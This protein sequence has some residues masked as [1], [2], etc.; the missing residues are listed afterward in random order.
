MACKIISHF[1][2]DEQ[3]QIQQ[4]SDQAEQINNLLKQE[5]HFLGY[6]G[7]G[8][9]F[10]SQD[11]KY[12]LKFFKIHHM[13]AP[14]AAELFP[15][16]LKIK[17]IKNELVNKKKMNHEKIFNSIKLAAEKFKAETG[18]LFVHLN[19]TKS[20]HPSVTLV[21]PIGV[22]I[23]VDLNQ[24][25]F[26]LQRKADLS[27]SE[28]KKYSIQKDEQSLQ[29]VIN[30]ITLFIADRCRKGIEDTDSGL[31]RNYSYC[32]SKLIQIDIGSF[33]E[34]SDLKN[35]QVAKEVLIKKTGLIRRVLTAHYP[36]MVPYLEQS[37][38]QSLYSD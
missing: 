16:L 6:G 31:F 7:Q 29:N 33:K 32:D 9:S 1:P 13:R 22:K 2:Y 28:I 8:Y 3:Y 17:M 34:N 18:I 30:D 26:V 15:F 12:V 27:I 10:A 21:S 4:T 38:E 35:K 20:Q 5:Y 19:T 14:R 24:T 23:Q 36:E 37:I 25:P 11:G